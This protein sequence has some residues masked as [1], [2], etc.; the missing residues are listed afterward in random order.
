MSQ[1]GYDEADVFRAVNTIAKWGLIEPESLIVEALAVEDAVRMHASGF[2]HMRFFL[3]RN[4]YLLALTTNLQFA[5]REVASEIGQLWAGQD[6]L[7]DLQLG[8]KLKIMTILRD[9]LRFEYTRR[10]RRHAFYE[11][12]GLGGRYVVEAIERAT[13]HM[14]T[15]FR[16]GQSRVGPKPIRRPQ[17]GYGGSNHTRSHRA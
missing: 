13:H 15:M 5:S 14:E 12:H 2:I 11:E 16:P 9:H 4:E 8:V 10:C 1:L 7:P 3:E 17:L 6:H